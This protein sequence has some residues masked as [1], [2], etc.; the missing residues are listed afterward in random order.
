MYIY[1]L[2][3]KLV[4]DGIEV[5]CIKKKKEKKKKCS[6]EHAFCLR[7]LNRLGVHICI[8]MS[9]DMHGSNSPPSL[10][11]GKLKAKK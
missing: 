11:E 6:L 9:C 1:E 8:Y 4:V 10:W 3:N 5:F 7:L 2:I